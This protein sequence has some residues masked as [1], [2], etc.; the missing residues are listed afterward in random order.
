MEHPFVERSK[1]IFSPPAYSQLN[2]A[3]YDHR[4]TLAQKSGI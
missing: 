3:C 1:V 2:I 4:D